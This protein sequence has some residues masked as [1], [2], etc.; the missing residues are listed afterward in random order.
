MVILV[1]A[2]P[3]HPSIKT[4]DKLFF[5]IVYIHKPLV[6]LTDCI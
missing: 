1:I 6:F 2:Q 3:T 4:P 5:K